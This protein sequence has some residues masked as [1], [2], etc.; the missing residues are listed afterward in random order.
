MLQIDNYLYASD[1]TEAYTTL[2][3]VPGSAVLGGCGYLRL[4]TRKITTAIDLSKLGLDYVREND[5]TV[6][7]GAMTSLRTI[8]THPSTSRLWSGVLKS[9]VRNIVGVQLR[10]GLTVGGTVA[11]RYPF[12]DPITA[13]LAL[14]AQLVF[15]HSGQVLLEDFL[16]GKGYR[17]VLEKIILP[18][19]SR[20]AAFSSIRKVKS[21]YAILNVAVAKKTTGYRIIVGSRPG[22]AMHV[23]ASA[24]Y[25]QEHGL[26]ANTAVEAGRLTALTVQFGDNPRGSGEYRKAVCPVLVQRALVEVINVS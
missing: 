13:L 6:E 19:D 21:D 5:D 8:E 1:L 12:S 24:D 3:S 22:R 17:D 16:H 20:L 25:L 2:H 9:A 7:I 14:D 26:D 4:G 10:S 18:K 15:H 23:S 11:G